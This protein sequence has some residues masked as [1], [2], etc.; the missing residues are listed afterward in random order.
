MSKQGYHLVSPSLDPWIHYLERL[1]QEPTAQT[2]ALLD[3]VMLQA[4]VTAEANVHVISGRL[5]DSGNISSDV[6][7][8][9]RTARYTAAISYGNGVP[10]AK[11]EFGETN[12][13]RGPRLDW[14]IHP[15]HDPYS[16]LE[17]YYA[18]ID[19]IIGAIG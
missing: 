12:E 11:Y 19:R 18:E 8:T 15:D 1:S 17:T 9:A 2:Q 10:Y 7:R 3:S 6:R 13:R 4:G 14:A 16:G 5:K